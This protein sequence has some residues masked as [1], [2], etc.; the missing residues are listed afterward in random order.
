M[1][2]SVLLLVFAMSL[3][4][5][6]CKGDRA[7]ENV[8]AVEEEVVVDKT[9][10]VTIDAT[11]KK[12]DDIA[13]Y[14]TTDGTAD[15]SKVTPIWQ[16]VK[17]SPSAQQITLKLPEGVKPTQFRID[18][19]LKA[20]QEDI[21]FNKI[22]FSHLGAE[23]TIACPEMVDFF[24]ADDNNCTFDPATGLIKAKIVNGKRAVP[25]IYP[26]EKNLMPELQKLH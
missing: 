1:K 9:F 19:G 6:S 13:V 20:N 2:K 4:V 17:G 10:N 14:Y 24:R 23:R 22:T 3:A 18:F 11:I 25:S 16:G 12:D 8:D 15:F 21:Y 26:Q 7:E 5:T